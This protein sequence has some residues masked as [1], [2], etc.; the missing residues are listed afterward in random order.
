M[1][2]EPC[3]IVSRD[4]RRF[5]RDGKYRINCRWGM[6]WVAYLH[7]R[8]VR[9]GCH[10]HPLGCSCKPVNLPGADVSGHAFKTLKNLQAALRK[11]YA[12]ADRKRK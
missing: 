5:T 10:K 4:G 8:C 3:R 2:G 1:R 12:V 9:A 7:S 6:F 11:K